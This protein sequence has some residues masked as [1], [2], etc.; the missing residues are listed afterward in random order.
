MSILSAIFSAVLQ[1]LASTLRI[2]RALADQKA[3][4]QDHT[5]RLE[6]IETLLLLPVAEK[7]S[8]NV[9]VDGH[10]TIGATMLTLTDSQK[11][12]LNLVVKDAKGKP[13]SLDGPAV[14]ASSDETVATVE[15]TGDLTATL[16]SVSPG[17]CKITATGDALIGDGTQ[18]LVGSLDVTVTPGQ[19]IQIDLTAGTPVDQ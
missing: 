8:F 11:S 19:A 13:T 9:T 4:L 17:T 1:L 10:T 7:I 15:S 3:M 14:F 12:D 2:E 18:P 16:T 6:R 5:E